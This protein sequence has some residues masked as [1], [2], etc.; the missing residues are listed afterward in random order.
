MNF[1]INENTYN[2]IAK[3]I[4]SDNSPVGIDAKKTHILILKALAD[5]TDKVDALQQ[6]IV[7][8]KAK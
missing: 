2:E 1:D 4:H 7:A 3:V 8:L 6:E 5:L